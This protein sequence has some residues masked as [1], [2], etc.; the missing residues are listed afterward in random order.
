MILDQECPRC[1]RPWGEHTLDEMK[2]HHPANALNL[3]F[4]ETQRI[5]AQLGA[6]GTPASAVIVRPFVFTMRGP[7][8][9]GCGLG[10]TFMGTDGLTEVAQIALILN[11][12]GMRNLKELLDQSID[13]AVKAAV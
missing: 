9:K 8:E 11:A 10:L 5:D 7:V 2:A 3:P 4:E 13:A 1:R 6:L 12:E